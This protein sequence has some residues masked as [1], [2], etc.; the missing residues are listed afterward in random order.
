MINVG[1]DMRIWVFK[2]NIV[3]DVVNEYCKSTINVVDDC[4]TSIPRVVW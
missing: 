3:S 2:G 4:G 1:T